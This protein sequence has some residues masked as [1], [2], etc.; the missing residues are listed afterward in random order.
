MIDER[1]IIHP[2]AIL[3]KNVSV[4][5]WSVIGENVTIGEGTEIGSHVVIGE[6]TRMGKGNKLSSFVSLGTDPQSIAYKGDETWLEIGDDNVIREFTTI[7]R[8]TK[9]G[10]RVTRVGSKNYL[11]AYSHVAHDCIVGDHVTFANLAQVAGHVEVGDHASLGAYT[12]VHQFCR[13]GAYTFLGRAAKVYQDIL[14]YM[15]VT[16][17][18]AVPTGINSIGLRRYGF[19]SDVMRVLKQAYQ[20]ICGRQLKLNEI[21][22]ELAQLSKKVPEIQRLFDMVSTSTRGFSRPVSDESLTNESTTVTGTDG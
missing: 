11:M 20:L 5:P 19:S 14:P 12:G 8:G 16:G 7:N 6:N 10:R 22:D 17:N 15:L 2:N 3:E 18:P 21:C 1:A 13:I 4:G 9:Q